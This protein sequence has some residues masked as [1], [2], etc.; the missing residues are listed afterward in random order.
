MDKIAALKEIKK[1]IEEIVKIGETNKIYGTGF[2]QENKLVQELLATIDEVSKKAKITKKF[3]IKANS[4][5]I[6]SHINLLEKFLQYI[7]E[8][9]GKNLEQGNIEEA[10]KYGTIF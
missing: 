1:L 7:E 8:Q 10:E 6:E 3:T 4:K 5:D 2:V 9:Y